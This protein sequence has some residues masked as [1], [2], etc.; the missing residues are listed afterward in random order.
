MQ[1]LC[2]RL[3]LAC[4]ITSALIINVKQYVNEL[5]Q[6]IQHKVKYPKSSS[7]PSD[8][9]PYMTKGKSRKPLTTGT[10]S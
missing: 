8:T 6:F 3:L 7:L 9:G 1:K 5:H 10:S 2:P 4:D